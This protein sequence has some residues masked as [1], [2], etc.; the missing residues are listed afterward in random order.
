MVANPCVR[1][2]CGLGSYY[3]RGTEPDQLKSEFGSREAT[4]YPHYLSLKSGGLTD[5]YED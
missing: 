4:P 1:P 2:A 5:T 3:E